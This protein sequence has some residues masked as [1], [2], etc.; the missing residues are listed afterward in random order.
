MTVY[1][2][3]GPLI[4]VES[5]NLL[6][7]DH[8]P[9]SCHGFDLLCWFFFYPFKGE[10][11]HVWLQLRPPSFLITSLYHQIGIWS[12]PKTRAIPTSKPRVLSYSGSNVQRL[13]LSPT[14]KVTQ[15]CLVSYTGTL[16]YIVDPNLEQGWSAAPLCTENRSASSGWHSPPLNQYQKSTALIIT[17]DLLTALRYMH[18]MCPHQQTSLLFSTVHIPSFAPQ[19][20]YN[21]QAICVVTACQQINVSLEESR[22]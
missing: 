15:C 6:G 12:R 14:Y 11:T 3:G 18:I 17:Q 13:M 20:H 19:A 9:I 2:P 21:V 22:Q 8:W 10:D 5:W 7:K 16:N 4:W 1:I